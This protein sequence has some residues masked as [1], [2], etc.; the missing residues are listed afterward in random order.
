VLIIVGGA[1]RAGKSILAQ[2]MLD[3]RKLAYFPTDILMMGLANA[4]PESGLKLRDPARA[5][6]AIMW[7]MLRAMATTIVENG[8]DYL[9]E[10]DVLMPRQVVELRERFGP[11]AIK[12]C[13]MGY[14]SVDAETKMRDIRR[15]AVGKKD[16]T[17]E[18]DDAHLLRLVCEFR[19][20]SQSLRDECRE[21]RLSY[22]DGSQSFHGAITEAATH[23]CG[24]L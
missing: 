9:L 7:P 6:A 19:E 18:C 21:F 1:P 22:F 16:W 24:G 10:G 20:F 15:F 3:E 4:M 11:A 14:A 12:S 17:N 5:R 23:L 8:D 13:F 2:R